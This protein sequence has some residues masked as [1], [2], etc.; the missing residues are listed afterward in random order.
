[1][2]FQA[3]DT[4]SAPCRAAAG[5]VNDPERLIA[6]YTDDV[7]YR[8]RDA[9][10]RRGREALLLHFRKLL[11]EPQVGVTHRARSRADGF[12]EPLH[13]S[14]A[15]PSTVEALASRLTSA[16]MPTVLTARR[17]LRARRARCRTSARR[18]PGAQRVERQQQPPLIALAERLAA[19]RSASG[20]RS[21]MASHAGALDA[22]RCARRR[23]R[24]RSRRFYPGGPEMR[25][26]A[27]RQNRP[28]GDQ[29]FPARGSTD[30]RPA[31][32]PVA[33]RATGRRDVAR[34]RPSRTGSRAARV[35]NLCHVGGGERA[36]AR[37]HPRRGTLR[38]D[39]G[40]QTRDPRSPDPRP[41]RV[42]LEPLLFDDRVRRR[43]ARCRKPRAG[44]RRRTTSSRGATSSRS[45]RT[46][47][48]SSNCSPA[49]SR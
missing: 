33:R 21:D 38:R 11:A 46:A 24:E 34:I 35:R 25:G 49:S 48:R 16:S 9:G 40:R 39:H 5:V 12:P 43:P 27:A 31:R 8:S 26:G 28:R 22:W 15:A 13:A 42:S 19:A 6:F 3:P 14:I 20:A 4:A 36:G 37:S 45:A 1:M 47:T 18:S 17:C 41:A 2:D 7:V 29:S 32:D 30:S 44:R 10:R 23:S